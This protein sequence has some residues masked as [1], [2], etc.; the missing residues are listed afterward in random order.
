M[1][2]HDAE[3]WIEQHQREQ[4][5]RKEDRHHRISLTLMAALALILIGGACSYNP[6]FTETLLWVWR[7][8]RH[9]PRAIISVRP[10]IFEGEVALARMAGFPI[11]SVETTKNPPLG[12]SFSHTDTLSYIIPP[13]C[14]IPPPAHILQ[15]FLC[16]TTSKIAER[17]TRM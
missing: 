12:A 2:D 3:T 8:S 11:F 14:I 15:F 10:V 1:S 13:S 17:P 4:A 5:E 9:R 6:R 16:V 7:H